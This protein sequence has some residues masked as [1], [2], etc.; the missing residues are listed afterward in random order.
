MGE[1]EIYRV[2]DRLTILKNCSVSI[3]KRYS[4]LSTAKI[5]II[6]TGKYLLSFILESKILFKGYSRLI[7]SKVDK[8]YFVFSYI[9]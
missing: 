5:Y 4:L 6:T 7:E 9:L 2:I 8:W 1:G 3:D